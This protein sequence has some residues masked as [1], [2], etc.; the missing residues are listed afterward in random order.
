MMSTSYSL[1]QCNQMLRILGQNRAQISS[2]GV[3]WP[4]YILKQFGGDV[5]FFFTNKSKLL[6]RVVRLGMISWTGPII[7]DDF[8]L[9]TISKSLSYQCTRKLKSLQAKV[10]IKDIGHLL[11]KFYKLSYIPSKIN[12]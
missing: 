8:W 12:I 2:Y 11:C 9:G 1:E 7:I 6:A 4:E 3:P 10:A 5:E